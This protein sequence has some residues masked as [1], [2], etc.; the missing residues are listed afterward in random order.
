MSYVNYLGWIS[1]SIEVNS[2]IRQGCPFSPMAF[3]LASE[4]LG[5]KIRKEKDIKGIKLPAGTLPH[6]HTHSL[7]IQLYADDISLFLQDRNDPK[8]ALTLV[9]YFS[10]FSGLHMNRVKSEA[11]WIGSNQ[12]SEER[13]F[14]IRWTK[15]LT[16]LGIYFESNTPASKNEK[17]WANRI[18]E[19][20]I[21]ISQWY[22]RN[23][24]NE[25]V[26]K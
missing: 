21:I 6:N 17:N 16:I 23:C 5:I 15:T 12:D 24:F 3:I 20:N 1:T 13:P 8:N 7:K 19:I 11:M 10:K 2:G 4:I 18:E 26:I 25:C 9:T 22:E 14:G